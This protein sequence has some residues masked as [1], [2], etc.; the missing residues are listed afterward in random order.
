MLVQRL[1]TNEIF[2]INSLNRTKVILHP[3]KRVK[4]SVSDYGLESFPA[5]IKLIMLT[6][7]KCTGYEFC[8][9]VLATGRFYRSWNHWVGWQQFIRQTVGWAWKPWILIRS[10]YIANLSC[11]KDYSWYPTINNW[12]TFF[13]WYKGWRL[14]IF[15][16]YSQCSYRRH[17]WQE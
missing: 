1:F 9:C 11:E 14:C 6:S 3:T 16:M 7:A 10:G 13:S 17:V 15:F 4:R 5:G 2:P 12:W 8:V